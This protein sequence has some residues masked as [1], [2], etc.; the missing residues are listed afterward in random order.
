MGHQK[1]VAHPKLNVTPFFCLA[2]QPILI[3]F[4]EGD[5]R[6]AATLIIIP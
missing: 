1:G 5:N 2:E 4:L 3:A 6:E